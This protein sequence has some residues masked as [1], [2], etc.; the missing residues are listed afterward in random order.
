MSDTVSP[1]LRMPKSTESG[2]RITS[3]NVCYTKLLRLIGG[4][5]HPDL[6]RS[7]VPVPCRI[8]GHLVVARRAGQ[9]DAL[10]PV[11]PLIGRNSDRPAH[12]EEHGAVARSYNF[13]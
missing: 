4:S 5:E 3:Y 2:Y 12:A 7:G 1:T 11:R 6:V 10:R 9:R 8:R 13:V